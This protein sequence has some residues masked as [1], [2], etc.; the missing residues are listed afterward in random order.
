MGE[1]RIKEEK[2]TESGERKMVTQNRLTIV[3]INLF[4]SFLL[5]NALTCL[6]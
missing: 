5:L 1:S 3:S 6:K 4:K 2:N